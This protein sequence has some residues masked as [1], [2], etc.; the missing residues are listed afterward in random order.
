MTEEM[1]M[2]VFLDSGFGGVLGG[3]LLDTAG[4]IPAVL[5]GFEQ[6]TVV[7]YG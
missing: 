3:N 6:V 1:R 5:A 2:H 7:G 4:C